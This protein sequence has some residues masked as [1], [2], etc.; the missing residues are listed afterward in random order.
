MIAVHM[1]RR[2]KVQRAASFAVRRVGPIHGSDGGL[3]AYV[4][5]GANAVGECGSNR[6]LVMLIDGDGDD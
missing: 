2:R 4:T 1:C 6:V 5:M 3:E